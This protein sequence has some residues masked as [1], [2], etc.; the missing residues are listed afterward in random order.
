A[1]VDRVLNGREGVRRQTRDHV[2]AIARKL[3]HG[4]ELGQTQSTAMRLDFVLPAG[5][6]SFMSLLR[7]HLL[8]E[9][10]CRP[11][12]QARLH[13]V[14][15]FNAEKLA[16]QL[17]QL[18]SNTDAV[19]VVGLDDP[20]VRDAIAALQ[21]SGIPVCTLVSDIPTSSRMGYVGIDNR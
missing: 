4:A 1:T 11:D 16:S 8:D 13:L 12:I 20:Q 14:E 5:D 18:Q 9:A 6:N 21:V 15:G 2:L 10:Q 7:Q 17:Y 3:G 19:G